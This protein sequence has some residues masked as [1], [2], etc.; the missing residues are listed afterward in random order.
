MN[1]G[2]LDK[3]FEDRYISTKEAANILGISQTLLS[4]WCTE[5]F[6]GAKV[7]GRFY[8]D[9]K[10]LDTF[11]KKR[12][13]PNFQNSDYQEELS[14]KRR[15]SRI[16]SQEAEKALETPPEA[17]AGKM[18]VRTGGIMMGRRRH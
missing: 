16:S 17:P 11:T 15:D 14:R 9:R 7:G 1:V 18:S 4:K 2:K 5:G 12:G 13:N 10:D 8:V 6:L 3:L